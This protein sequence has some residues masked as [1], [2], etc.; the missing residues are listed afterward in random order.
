MKLL[1]PN[2][3]GQTLDIPND[4]SEGFYDN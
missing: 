4:N 2:D 1:D 3:K